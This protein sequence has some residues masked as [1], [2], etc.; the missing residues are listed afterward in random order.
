MKRIRRKYIEFSEL[1]N[2]LD[3]LEHADFYIHQVKTNIKAWKW[4]VITLFGALYGFAVCALKGTSSD[5]VTF[6]TKKGMKKLISFD[7]ALKR[8]QDLKCM[9]MTVFSK[10]LKL[11]DQ[12]RKSIEKL[13]NEF[14]NS[15]EHF[16]PKSWYIE[17]HG[18]PQIAIDVLEVIQFLALECGNYN[19]LM[20]SQT[21]KKKIKSIIS[22][23][24]SLLK[25]SQLYK[26][27]CLAKRMSEAK[28]LTKKGV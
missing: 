5:N 20:L 26:E 6:K 28:K 12:Q 25:Q 18:M 1:T 15:F 4:V 21:Q 23:S 9:R 14:R 10:S 22:K 11:T 27:F 8:C 16:I 13:K 2:T 24:I 7:D 3:Y 17:T 19:C